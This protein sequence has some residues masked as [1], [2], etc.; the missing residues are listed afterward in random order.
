MSVTFEIP[1]DLQTIVETIP[2]L[3]VRMSLFLRHLASMQPH[4][5][6]M[7]RERSR[8]GIPL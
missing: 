2:D 3:E 6:Q 8:S 4:R 5:K 7:R 1:A